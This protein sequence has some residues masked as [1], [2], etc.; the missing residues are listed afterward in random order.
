[1]ADEPMTVSTVEEPAFTSCTPSATASTLSDTP[2]TSR[3]TSS[4]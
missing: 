1:M 4:L 3:L 2:A